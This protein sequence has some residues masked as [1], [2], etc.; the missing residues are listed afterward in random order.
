[1]TEMKGSD[2]Q[3]TEREASSEF[4]GRTVFD[5]MIIG[6]TAIVNGKNYS[7]EDFKK[8]VVMM[9]EGNGS[10]LKKLMTPTELVNGS[11]T[12]KQ[13]RKGRRMPDG[14]LK[15]IKGVFAA[16]TREQI[17]LAFD[18]GIQPSLEYSEVE[19]NGL[20]VPK[21]EIRFVNDKGEKEEVSDEKLAG[22]LEVRDSFKNLGF[23]IKSTRGTTGAIYRFLT[24]DIPDI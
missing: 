2:S 14:S 6:S 4:D 1:M 12:L 8:D 13:V 3:K 20:A 21:W 15:T 5:H 23:K 9:K 11:L 7:F 24:F 17:G 22:R 19:D 18:E 10:I 16:F